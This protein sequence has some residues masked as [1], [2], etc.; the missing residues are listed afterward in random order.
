VTD[1]QVTRR[2]YTEQP[3]E[4]LA[5]VRQSF[6]YAKDENRANGYFYMEG[7]QDWPSALKVFGPEL[8]DDLEARLGV[9][10][11]IVVFQA[12]RDGSGCGW[13]AD[14]GYSTQAIL[15]L[16]VTRKF[17]IRKPDG[18]PVWISVNH[19]DLVVMPPGFQSEWQHSVLEEDVIGERVSLVF[20]AV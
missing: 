5:R 14:D 18:E 1:L 7:G 12:Y 13:H 6:T 16:G 20:R 15:S 3:D 19:A 10:F 8:I 2:W 11:T 4:L 9:R 17:G